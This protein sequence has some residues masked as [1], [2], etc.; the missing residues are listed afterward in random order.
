M[1]NMSVS[2]CG[3]NESEDILVIEFVALCY[4]SNG[5]RVKAGCVADKQ[6]LDLCISKYRWFFGFRYKCCEFA[7]LECCRNRFFREVLKQLFDL[8]YVILCDLD[9]M[10]ILFDSHMLRN[11]YIIHFE[12]TWMKFEYCFR[13]CDCRMVLRN[14]VFPG[15]VFEE[16]LNYFF[17]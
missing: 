5:K 2:C 8:L 17:D 4:T 14:L 16:W 12:W 15:W 1:R 11:R 6:S 13:N 10:W 7:D 3:T 9:S